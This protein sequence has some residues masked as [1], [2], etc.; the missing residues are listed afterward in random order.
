MMFQIYT[1]CGLS[2]LIASLYV[3]PINISQK[4]YNTK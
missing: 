4:V 3:S 1:L 2:K